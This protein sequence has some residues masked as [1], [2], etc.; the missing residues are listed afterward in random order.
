[1]LTDNASV[2]M[3][4]AR[5]NRILLQSFVQF[6]IFIVPCV[7]GFVGKLFFLPS[8]IGILLK[9]DILNYRNT[10]IGNANFTAI[11]ITFLSHLTSDWSPGKTALDN[12]GITSVATVCSC[13]L[14][15]FLY[16]ILLP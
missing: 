5:E 13:G 15:P 16:L 7:Y 2:A 11:Q 3:Q 14:N 4:R 1:M 6:L 10:I 8:K 9:I 12:Y